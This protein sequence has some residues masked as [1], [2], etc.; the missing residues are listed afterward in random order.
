LA[1]NTSRLIHSTCIVS[2]IIHAYFR[3]HTVYGSRVLSKPPRMFNKLQ[4]VKYTIQSIV[5][6]SHVVFCCYTRFIMY[7]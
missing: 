3:M 1:P 7:G 5:G 4:N 2:G 6:I